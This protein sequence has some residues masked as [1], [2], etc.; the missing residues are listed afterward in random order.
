MNTDDILAIRTLIDRYSDAANRCDP[1]DMAAVYAED[2]EVVPL[3]GAPIRG[4]KALAEV[5][6]QTISQMEFINQVCSGIV[7]EQ[8]ESGATSRC[9][10]TEFAKR[11]EKDKLDIFLGTY[12]DV[13]VRTDEGWLFARRVL[14]RREQARL[15]ATL[16]SLL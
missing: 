9:T 1:E 6:A 12:E 10:V 16:R 11:R 13:L 4:R 7:I 14:S 15:E 8:T 2:G 5:F 3:G